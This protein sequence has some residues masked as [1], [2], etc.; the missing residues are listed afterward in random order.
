M[1]MK[2]QRLIV[3]TIV[4]ATLASPTL[5]FAQGRLTPP[6]PPAPTM[7]S[8]DQIEPRKA[9]SFSGYFIDSPGSYYVTT[10]LTG[11]SGHGIF[12]ASDNVTID[13][14]GFT[15]QGM[16]GSLSGVHIGGSRT[17]IVVRNGTIMGW[18]NDGVSWNYPNFPASQNIVLNRL[19]VSGNGH[20]GIAIPNNC[21]VSEC[22]V[23]NNQNFGIVVMGDGSQVIGNTLAGNN[24]GN[25]ANSAG[26]SISGSNNRI[27]NNHVIGSGAAGY[28]IQFNNAGAVNNIIIKNT[29]AGNGA[30]NYSIAGGGANDIGP[31]GTAASST[32]PWA[33][34]SH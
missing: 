8:L 31:V 14:N 32:S 22:S 11:I 4:I 17:N 6:G 25:D 28:G 24:N 26:I 18:G 7:K 1:L 5:A 23:Q 16:P 9:I 12:V 29:V 3:T 19:I 21:V 33:N 27:E 20:F 34:I 13:L 2:I 10:N 30:K 15:L